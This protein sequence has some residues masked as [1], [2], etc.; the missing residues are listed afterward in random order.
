MMWFSIDVLE[1][2]VP[3]CMATVSK[4]IRRSEC[5]IYI[6]DPVFGSLFK[7]IFN[8]HL[9][10]LFHMRIDNNLECAA[11]RIIP[12]QYIGVRSVIEQINEWAQ[13]AVALNT[14]FDTT[15]QRG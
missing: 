11:S 9:V 4:P 8:K 1:H 7:A 13:G 3:H 2:V 5:L 6:F 15:E 14:W 12:S 10:A